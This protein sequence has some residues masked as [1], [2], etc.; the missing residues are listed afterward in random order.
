MLLLNTLNTFSLV[1]KTTRV[2][3]DD[4]NSGNRDYNAFDAY[5]AEFVAKYG[6]DTSARGIPTDAVDKYNRLRDKAGVTAAPTEGVYK[7]SH[8]DEAQTYLH[9]SVLTKR[10]VNG[11]RVLL[12]RRISERLGAGKKKKGF[13]TNLLDVDLSYIEYRTQ[14][15]DKYNVIE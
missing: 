12:Y 7:S 8:F 10:T 6:D 3:V 15:W 4:A 9:T 14:L 13:K 5:R 1:V 11:E 2:V